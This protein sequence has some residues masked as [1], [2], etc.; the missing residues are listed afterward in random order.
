MGAV[1][2]EEAAAGPRRPLT[3]WLRNQPEAGVGTGPSRGTV[4]LHEQTDAPGG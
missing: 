2:R 1:R 3:V 4:C